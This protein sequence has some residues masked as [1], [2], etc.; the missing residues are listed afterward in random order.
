MTRVKVDIVD[1][2]GTKITPVE[3]PR[4]VPLRSLIPALVSK[5]NL[6]I[7]DETGSSVFYRMFCHR[8][9]RS[10]KR[11]DTLAS[12]GVQNGDRFTLVP[13]IAEV[14]HPISYEEPPQ[15]Q[16]V[17]AV[18]LSAPVFVPSS[19][20]LAIGLVPASIVDRWEEYRS[21]QMRWEV[22]AWAFIGATLG[23]IINWV[24]TNLIVISRASL[25]VIGVFVLMTVL[26]GL[27]ARDYKSRADEMK[28]TILSISNTSQKLLE[29]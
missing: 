11:D 9:N 3:L 29:R 20:S 21:D 27:A 22:A 13:K 18:Y 8:T 1:I 6:P 19:E 4:D 23:I 16:V 5:L 25:I 26:T 17:E 28:S 14:D 10:L 24:T 12:E 2:S 7:T 15:K